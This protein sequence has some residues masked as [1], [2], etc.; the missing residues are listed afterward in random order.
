MLAI[1]MVVMLVM[2]HTKLVLWHVFCLWPKNEG[3]SSLG[4]GAGTIGGIQ[5]TLE[6]NW[7]NIGEGSRGRRFAKLQNSTNDVTNMS[8]SQLEV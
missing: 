1:G 3:G 7:P 6:L 5:G 4:G 8:S 2:A